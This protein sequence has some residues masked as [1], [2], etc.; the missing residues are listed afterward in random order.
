M[1]TADKVPEAWAKHRATALKA[2]EYGL[3][4]WAE[5]DILAALLTDPL[6]WALWVHPQFIVVTRIV[7]YPRHRVFEIFLCSGEGLKAWAHYEELLCCWG[8]SQGCK[9]IEMIGRPGWERVKADGWEKTGIRLTKE[10]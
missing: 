5:H 3:G 1:I 4:R 10:L 9:Q 6:H 2:F 8:R 7:N